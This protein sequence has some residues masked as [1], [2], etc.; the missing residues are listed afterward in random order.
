LTPIALTGTPGTGKT[1]IARRLAGRFDTREV[2]ELA[3][4]FPSGA[5]EGGRRKA[6]V[7]DLSRIGQ[8]LERPSGRRID[9]VVGHLSHL[10]PV[11]DVVVLRCHP[12]ELERRLRRARRPG[13]DTRPNLVAEATDLILQEALALRRR[14]W[15]IDTTRRTPVAVAREVAHRIV[16]RGRSSY[17]SV[18]WLSDPWVTEHLL[19]WSR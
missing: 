10:L 17:G 1:T 7:V 13:R 8:L 3:T 12:R 9:V 4:G 2:H 11:K 15:E 19:D 14:V 5:R 6:R 18:D 16:H